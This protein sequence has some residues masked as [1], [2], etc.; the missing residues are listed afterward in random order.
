MQLSAKRRLCAAIHEHPVA[1]GSLDATLD[2]PCCLTRPRT[3]RTTARQAG[4][5]SPRRPPPPPLPP[6]ARQLHMRP[7]L[8]AP[9][10]WCAPSFQTTPPRMQAAGRTCR[11]S[12]PREPLQRFG[13]AMLEPHEASCPSHMLGEARFLCMINSPPLMH[14]PLPPGAGR[15]CRVAAARCGGLRSARRPVAYGG[16]V[17]SS[18][19]LSEQPN[20]VTSFLSAHLH[21][22]HWCGHRSRSQQAK[23]C[24]SVSHVPRVGTPR[25]VPRPAGGRPLGALPPEQP[26]KGVVL[27]QT[28]GLHPVIRLDRPRM[29]AEPGPEAATPVKT[30]SLGE[31]AGFS[32]ACIPRRGSAHHSAPP[33]AF[34]L[35]PAPL[36]RLHIFA[37]IESGI[38]MYIFLRQPAAAGCSGAQRR[39]QAAGHGRHHTPLQIQVQQVA[40]RNACV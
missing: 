1:P 8:L 13:P 25:F 36:P 35:P 27:R 12:Q 32:F 30:Y 11:T 16:L 19:W 28:R 38:Y 3:R 22:R 6:Q 24:F 37:A 26:N 18:R 9:R 21:C 20:T 34:Q 39:A 33:A 2:A 17:G 31:Q 29:R 15:R 7:P 4:A 14:H 5:S 40:P 10:S 23:R